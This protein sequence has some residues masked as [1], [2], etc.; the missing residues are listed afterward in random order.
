MRTNGSVRS[1]TCVRSQRKEGRQAGFGKSS[2]SRRGASTSPPCPLVTVGS[3]MY[4]CR[5]VNLPQLPSAPCVGST[6]IA[7]ACMNHISPVFHAWRMGAMLGRKGR[8][9]NHR[10]EDATKQEP[11][12]PAAARK[13]KITFWK[14]AKSAKRFFTFFPSGL[15]L[16]SWLFPSLGLFSKN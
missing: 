10:G 12:C 16:H 1:A 14:P 5:G 9:L 2:S 8:M 6:A 4:Q 7:L 15:W 13:C 11:K 3:F